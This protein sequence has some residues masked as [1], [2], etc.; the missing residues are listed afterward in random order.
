MSLKIIGEQKAF[1]NRLKKDIM[2]EIFVRII[3]IG[4]AIPLIVSMVYGAAEHVNL[5][6]RLSILAW[7]LFAI[8]IGFSNWD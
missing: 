5:I 6:G 8:I 2:Q 1:E 3:I 4:I 7:A